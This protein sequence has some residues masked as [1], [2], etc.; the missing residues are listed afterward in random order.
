MSL[1]LGIAG[2]ATLLAGVLIGWQTHDFIGF[3]VALV[4]AALSSTLFFG[5]AGVLSNQESI[6]YRLQRLEA[7]ERGRPEE[8]T[9]CAKCGRQYAKTMSYCSWCGFRD[10]ESK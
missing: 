3:I 8:K 7:P 6:L 1:L 2:V 10:A 5:L 4:S 9:T